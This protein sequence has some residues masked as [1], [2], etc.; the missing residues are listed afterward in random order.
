MTRS[1]TEFIDPRAVRAVRRVL[2][3]IEGA[4]EHVLA[5]HEEPRSV[6]GSWAPCVAGVPVGPW[7]VEGFAVGV[8]GAR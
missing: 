5:Q 3:D 7:T 2:A 6:P 1:E 8:G 4:L